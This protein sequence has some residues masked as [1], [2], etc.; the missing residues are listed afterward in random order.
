MPVRIIY[1]SASSMPD[2]PVWG[3]VHEIFRELPER[4]LAKVSLHH[5]TPGRQK[6]LFGWNFSGL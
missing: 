4:L 3:N 6:I 1:I 5:S 2:L